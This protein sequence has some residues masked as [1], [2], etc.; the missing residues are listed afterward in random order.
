MIVE[1][2]DLS[3]E[4]GIRPID[5]TGLLGDQTSSVVLYIPL[6]RHVNLSFLDSLIATLPSANR[7]TASLN[8]IRAHPAEAGSLIGSATAIRDVN[9]R[10]ANRGFH[11]LHYDGTSYVLRELADTRKLTHQLDDIQLTRLLS[12][13]ELTALTERPGSLL[14]ANPN[15]HYEGPNGMHYRS[16]LR[17]GS[18]LS[19]IEALDSVLFWMLEDLLRT[20]LTVLDSGTI[21]SL[22]LRASSYLKENGYA[23]EVFNDRW[24]ECLHKYDESI[25]EVMRRI[26]RL[27]IGQHELPALLVD[28]VTSTGKLFSRLSEAC[29]KNGIS[30][31]RVSIFSTERYAKEDSGRTLAFLHATSEPQRKADCEL[32]K[33]KSQALPI[34][35]QSYLLDLSAASR[36]TRIKRSDAREASEFFNKYKGTKCIRVHIT[37]HDQRHHMID[38]DVRALLKSAQFSKRLKELCLQLGEDADVVLHP[39][40]SVARALGAK[41]SKWLGLTNI[42]SDEHRLS[43]LSDAE[44]TTLKNAKTVLILDDVV[45]TGT[46]MRGYKEALSE[47][48][49]SNVEIRG[50]V[51]VA[52]PD[53]RRA[54]QGISDMFGGGT[55]KNF[56]YVNSLS[57]LIGTRTTARGVVN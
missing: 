41:V 7:R 15:F 22:A 39:E 36:S 4:P 21:L 24:I 40:H 55:V 12:H 17:L 25:D 52:R 34:S 33:A 32:C 23:P 13:A 8:V 11:L 42:A 44:L 49:D 14:P 57:C 45:V 56:E 20:K 48:V 54:L 47:I 27:K 46:R 28:S 51:G 10:L 50:L 26:A 2:A 5:C 6:P 19:S 43:R 16:F 18:A 31:R 3:H 29:D 53:S 38:I 30:T 1:V 37:E 35:P 9:Q